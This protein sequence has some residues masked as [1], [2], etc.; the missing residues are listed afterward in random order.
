MH[1]KN[2]LADSKERDFFFKQSLKEYA[3]AVKTIAESKELS[4]AYP[5][6]KLTPENC[7]TLAGNPKAVSKVARDFNRKLIERDLKN[8]KGASAKQTKKA[9]K[10]PQRS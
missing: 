8:N 10:T 2:R 9:D 5:D 3:K 1:T 7:K 4:K 6:S